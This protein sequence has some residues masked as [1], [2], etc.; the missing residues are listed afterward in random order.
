MFPPKSRY[1]DFE[2]LAV[3]KYPKVGDISA[4]S[5]LTLHRGTPN[6]SDV[7]RPVVVLG[8]D[9]AGAGNHE[10]HDPAVTRG[11]WEALPERVRQHLCVDVVDTLTPITQKHTI[12]GLVMGEA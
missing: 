9:A 1:P 12:E 6:R 7:T 8:V 3:R 5:A 2:A 4:R 11:Y 10:H